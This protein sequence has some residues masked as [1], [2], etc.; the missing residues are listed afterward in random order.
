MLLLIV[1]TKESHRPSRLQPKPRGL[2]TGIENQQKWVEE[3]SRSNLHSRISKNG[4]K[5]SVFLKKIYGKSHRHI[6]DTLILS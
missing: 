6:W 3:N 2:T 1:Q 4:Q 5:N